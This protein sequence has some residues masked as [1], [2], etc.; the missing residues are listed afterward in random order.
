MLGMCVFLFVWVWVS[1]RCLCAVCGC[2]FLLCCG[3]GMIITRGCDSVGGF[4]FRDFVV[5]LSIIGGVGF[6]GGFRCGLFFLIL[7]VGIVLVWCVFC[8]VLF[9][10]AG[11][12]GLV[13]CL[14]VCLGQWFFCWFG[15]G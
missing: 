9:V 1:L 6:S 12:N 5:F 3:V 11:E 8:V 7:C 14:S 10:L 15:C 4:S 13:D 2:L